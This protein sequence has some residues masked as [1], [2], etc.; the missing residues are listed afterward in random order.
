MES[1][2]RVVVF[3]I[4]ID[5]RVDSDLAKTRIVTFLLKIINSKS[6]SILSETD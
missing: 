3:Y 5:T 4:M 2:F 6:E 1:Q